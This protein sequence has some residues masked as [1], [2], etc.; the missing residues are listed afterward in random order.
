MKNLL[1]L[2]IIIISTLTSCDIQ[3]KR[4]S[5]GFTISKNRNYSSG[6]NKT[7]EIENDVSDELDTLNSKTVFIPTE[8]KINTELAKPSLSESIV[9]IVPNVTIHT[10]KTYIK[11]EKQT[12]YFDKSYNSHPTKKENILEKKKFKESIRIKTANAH[13]NLNAIIGIILAITIL[14]A[15][16][17]YI[18][19]VIAYIQINLKP[20]YYRK[21]T[22]KIINLSLI[23]DLVVMVF[24]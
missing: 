3:K 21:S 8:V 7:K 1:L 2:A 17:S 4:Y 10:K 15:F 23:L 6:I 13:I 16:I 9:K 12:D 18:F 20:N 14:G 11:Q 22:I 24:G 19:T 5:R